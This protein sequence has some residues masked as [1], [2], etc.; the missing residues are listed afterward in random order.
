MLIAVNYHY[1]RPSGESSGGI[2]PVSVAAFESQLRSLAES[3]DFISGADLIAAVRGERSLPPNACIVT[4]DDGLAEQY[5]YA[6]PVLDR[7]RIPAVFFCCSLPLGG[8]ALTV[9]KTHWLQST[10]TAAAFEEGLLAAS[11]TLGIALPFERVDEATA[12]E[13]YQYDA[14]RTRTVKY[15]LNHVLP[16]DTYEALVG[17][18]FRQECDEREFCRT[19]YMSRARIADLAGRHTIGS[20]A[21]SHRPLAI[22]APDTAQQEFATSRDALASVTGLS[23]SLLSYPYGGTTAVSREMADAA[24][25]CGYEAAFTMERAVNNDVTDPL[26]LA[27]FS[28]SDVPG[29]TRALVSWQDARCVVA[30][31]ATAG[32]RWFV[33]ETL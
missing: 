25:R 10:R 21:H 24:A 32:R 13:Q 22:A 31:P 4:F 8:R 30:S 16:F 7:L 9:H 3:V 19:L 2:Y 33:H 29:G 6:A 28:A 1:V 15:L 18:L 12:A 5:E 17:E 14:P 23:I 27:R 26:L 20:H 11:S